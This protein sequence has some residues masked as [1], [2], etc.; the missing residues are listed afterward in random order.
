MN[1]KLI[2]A[3]AIIAVALSIWFGLDKEMAREVY[4]EYLQNQDFER[5]INECT[6]KIKKTGT[7]LKKAESLRTQN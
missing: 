5:T 2:P 7:R 4:V 3:M 1:S 6:F